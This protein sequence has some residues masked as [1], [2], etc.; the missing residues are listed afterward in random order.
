MSKHV[1]DCK[2]LRSGRGLATTIEK[3]LQQTAWY[4]DRSGAALGH[5]LVVD[6][7]EGKSWDERI[8]RREARLAKTS[9]T[10]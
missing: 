7:R 5:L 8:F 4:I 1:I 2:A 10:V 3:G 6:Q 9:I